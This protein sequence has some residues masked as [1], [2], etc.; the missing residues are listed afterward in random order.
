MKAREAD[1]EWG[2]LAVAALV[3]AVAGIVVSTMKDPVPW[4]LTVSI[5]IAFGIFVVA[6]SVLVAQPL[7][8]RRHPR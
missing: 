2:A 7:L 6:A 8:R 5:A 4:Y 1:R 3:A